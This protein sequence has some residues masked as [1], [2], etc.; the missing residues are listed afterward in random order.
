MYA[1]NVT[2][3]V[4]SVDTESG[5][6][7]NFL[8]YHIIMLV[9]CGSMAVV[10]MLTALCSV[11]LYGITPAGVDA[12]EQCVR[13]ALI[14]LIMSLGFDGAFILFYFLCFIMIFY[15]TARFCFME[16]HQA[17]A[18]TARQLVSCVVVRRSN[19]IAAMQDAEVMVVVVSVQCPICLETD[20]GPWYT[21]SCGH[22]FHTACIQKWNR[23]TCPLCR[24]SVA[25]GR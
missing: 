10:F 18:H 24:G 4:N 5:A 22:V 20:T 12:I 1:C 6:M 17:I 19:S 15:T 9:L 8:N 3:L 14:M 25:I 13:W 11:L 7:C 16:M 23:N 2:F 21:T